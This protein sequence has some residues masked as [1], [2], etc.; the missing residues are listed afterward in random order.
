MNI[1]GVIS[2]VFRRIL[3]CAALIILLMPA[4]ALPGQSSDEVT[5]E[6]QRLYA[7]AKSA[8]QSGNDAAA[9]EKYRAIL[10]LAP[11]LAAAYNNLGML[12][13]NGQDYEHAA[14]ILKHG[15]E[16]N[17]DMPT[18]NAMLGMSYVQLGSN[19]SAEP[20]LKKVLR[21]NP[22]DDRIEMML[23]H[24]LISDGK[25]DD[26]IPYLNSFL[27]RNPKN[28]E[29]WY[30]LGKTYLHLSEDALGKIN[31]IDPNSVV[32]HE[33]SGEID[34][35]MHNYELALVEYKK[36]IDMAPQEPGTHMH[37]AEAYWNMGKWESA[38]TEF[39]A[40]LV[41]DP[42]NCV[43][44]WKLANSVLEA[45]GSNDVALADLNRSIE[46][47]PKLMQ[48][49]VDRARALVRLGKQPDAL[50][51]LLLAVKD[52]P[53]EPSIHF[54]LAAVYRAEGKTAEAQQEMKMYAQL[55]RDASATVAGQAS[56]ASAVKSN[57]N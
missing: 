42:N 54:L 17:P 2:A 28:Q 38:Q 51:D 13:F 15:L 20:I 52:S 11:H 21:T 43:A 19:E 36:A 45:N 6:V 41:N 12:Y 25:F 22:A 23:I 56:D 24:V 26:S 8:Q 35:S 48:A 27:K 49:R 40:E 30:L 47:C 10:K 16:I 29:A 1:H 3:R 32:A 33:I 57:P 9:I 37:M 4:L 50:P 5:P 46:R 34:A 53:H 55:Q 31:E 44:R 18:A 39:S 14:T 7:E